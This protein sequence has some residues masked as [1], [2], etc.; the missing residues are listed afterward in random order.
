[1]I[2]VK[3][4]CVGTLKEKYW[5][6]ACAEYEKRLQGCCKFS[7]KQLKEA[8]LPQNPSDAEITKALESEGKLIFEEAAGTLAFPLCIEGKEFSSEEL[9][10]RLESA[11]LSGNSSVS[12]IIGSSHGLAPAVKEL[13]VKISM[14]PMTFPHQLARVML[15]EQ[16]YRAF[17]IS[18][19]TK[20]HK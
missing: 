7:I 19:A 9:S 4:I 11:A 13:G 15:C 6:D 2:T 5:R 20:Y 1:M 16:I 12:F 14:S 10:K 8:K 18:L 3:L 17:Q